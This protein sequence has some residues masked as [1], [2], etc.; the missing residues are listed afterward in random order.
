MNP[1]D[2]KL[3]RMKR[4]INTLLADIKNH[5]SFPATVDKIIVF[6]SVLT[7]EFNEY[8]DMDICIVYIAEPDEKQK[9]GIENYFNDI[10]QKEMNVDFTYC[11]DDTLKSGQQVFKSIREKGRVLYERI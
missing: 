4:A 11:T 6:G 2:L 5:R 9:H 10:L 1:T 8:S 7:D 3:I